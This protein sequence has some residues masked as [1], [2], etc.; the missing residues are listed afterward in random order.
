MKRWLSYLNPGVPLNPDADF[1]PKDR[2]LTDSELD[3]YVIKHMSP[4]I[5]DRIK[6][7]LDQTM[8][9]VDYRKKAGLAS[10]IFIGI[11]F[12]SILTG[13]L[14]LQIGALLIALWWMLREGAYDRRIQNQ[15]GFIDGLLFVS[16][17]MSKCVEEAEK[18]PEVM[19]S[20]IEEAKKHI[21][22]E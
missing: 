8:Q 11:A 15:F 13:L 4:D 7:V 16:H 22:H 19:K 2:H 12:V 14:A 5:K 1:V 9:D 21:A 10:L 17:S 18:D 6:L 3:S 20:V